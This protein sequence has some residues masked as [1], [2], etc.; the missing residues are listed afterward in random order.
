MRSS[1]A[2]FSKKCE[3]PGFAVSGSGFLLRHAWVV[4]TENNVIDPTWRTA[5][6]AYRRIALP[7]QLVATVLLVRG[8]YRVLADRDNGYPV[9]QQRFSIEA[10]TAAYERLLALSGA[11]GPGAAPNY[12][13]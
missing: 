1:R 4:D 3:K 13:P 12:I 9:L 11:K 7:L 10:A 8:V 6:V 5:G 2:V